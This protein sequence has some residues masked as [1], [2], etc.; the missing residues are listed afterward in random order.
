SSGACWL[1]VYLGRKHPTQE[2]LFSYSLNGSTTNPHP[3]KQ[4]KRLKKL[5]KALLCLIAAVAMLFTGLTVG[6]APAM[7]DGDPTYTV[8]IKNEV[9]GYTYEAYQVFSGTLSEKDSKTTLSSIVWGNGV[10]GSNLLSALK[11]VSTSSDSKLIITKTE[12]EGDDVKTTKVN[13]FADIEE[14]EDAAKN[15]ANVLGQN[16][17]NTDFVKAFAKIA[18]ANKSATKYVSTEQK[19]GEATTGYQISNLPAGYYLILNSS[20]PTTDD[21]AYTEYLLEVVKNIPNLTPKSQVPTH[22]KK[23][24]EKNDSLAEST[25]D[26]K[27]PTD[28]QD[29][30][31][32]DI[33]DSVP[34]KITGT[35]PAD[36]D[37]FAAYDTYKFVFHDQQDAG[38]TFN[39]D[40]TLTLIKKGQT[41]GTTIPKKGTKD[42]AEHTN[43]TVNY[44]VDDQGVVTKQ[45][46]DCTFEI[47]FTDVKSLYDENGNKIEVSAGDSIVAEYTSKLNKDAVIGKPGNINK[48]HLEYSNNPNGDGTGHTPWDDVT[49]F[50]FELEANKVG[51]DRNTALEGAGFSLYKWETKNKK[52]QWVKKS[53]I[54]PFQKAAAGDV[55][56]EWGYKLVDG[57][58]VALESNKPT[59]FTWPGIDSGKYKIEESTV[60]EPYNKINDKIFWVEATY[61]TDHDEE[62][63]AADSLTLTFYGADADG[64]L[65][66]NTVL[67]G[68]GK[69]WAIKSL[70]TGTGDDAVTHEQAIGSITIQNKKGSELPETGGIG[71]TILYVAGAACVIAAG[72]WFALRRR[73]AR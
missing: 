22:N 4:H 20:V 67:S 25:T 36:T 46:D 50:T 51:E 5:G 61:S 44:T 64:N 66:R 49:V 17:S 43:Y 18:A 55:A 15:V 9:T 68:D 57:K 10:N 42:G 40:A 34:F 47:S 39:N 53:E 56:D 19:N 70:T 12:G 65:D 31:D 35:L 38:L 14:N 58:R 23:V 54:A 3:R 24:Q 73:N 59:T 71:T 60:P 27:N 69:E 72:V 52:L 16:S 63:P 62:T 7:A 33:G 45:A 32:Y 21:A 13:P 8:T 1:L 30:A 48:S 6:A 29:G 11:A 26:P 37:R 2:A 28:W 41:T